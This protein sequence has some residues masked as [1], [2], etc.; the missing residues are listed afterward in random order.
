MHRYKNIAVTGE[1]GAG[2]STLC[3]WL[4]ERMG[5]RWAGFQTVRYAVADAGPLYELVDI[6]TGEGVPISELRDGGIRGI[7][8][9]FDTFGAACLRRAAASDA[10]VLLLD[11]IGRFERSSRVFL[12]GV[13][14]VLDGE[15][16]V[17]AV[18]KQEALPHIQAIRARPDTLVVD[19]DLLGKEEARKL[20]NT[21]LGKL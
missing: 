7:P 12:S 5:L 3:A 14:A 16:T 13:S 9:S 15:K 1:K 21:W 19:L 17:I 10:P 8:G 18:L 2:K 20:L 6:L 4:L 11:E